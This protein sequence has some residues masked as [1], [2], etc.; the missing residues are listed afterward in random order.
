[1]D[2]MNTEIGETTG[3]EIVLPTE[4]IIR[5][6]P[7]ILTGSAPDQ[8]QARVERFFLSVADTDRGIRASFD[9]Q[10]RATRPVVDPSVSF[11][12]AF[13]KAFR[14]LSRPIGAPSRH[15]SSSPVSIE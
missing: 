11:R 3:R 7:P 9:R 15:G 4:G 12:S 14:P 10:G 5:E 2:A 1:M 8:V 13:L 6:L